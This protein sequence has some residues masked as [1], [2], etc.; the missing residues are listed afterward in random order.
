MTK[1]LLITVL[2]IT[3]CQAFQEHT[4][5]VERIGECTKETENWFSGTTTGKCKV[6]LVDGKFLSVARP[7]MVGQ[8]V[9][10]WERL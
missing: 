4:S 6:L 10:Y 3:G 5:K 7:V 1:V 8:S 2:L 9:S